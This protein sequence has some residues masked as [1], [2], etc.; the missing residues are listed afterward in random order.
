MNYIKIVHNLLAD[1]INITM[2]LH[3]IL[4]QIIVN[5]LLLLKIKSFIKILAKLT[6]LIENP[7]SPLHKIFINTLNGLAQMDESRAPSDT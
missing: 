5:I 6:L 2:L 3:K 4:Q 7:Q 1:S